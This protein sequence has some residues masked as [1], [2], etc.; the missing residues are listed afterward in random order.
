MDQKRSRSLFGPAALACAAALVLFTPSAQAQQPTPVL[1]N[2]VP[3]AVSGGQAALVQ[4]PPP[5]QQLYFSIAL[6]LR[7]RPSCRIC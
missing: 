7:D 6:P 4:L 5:T 3:V 2:N 1:S